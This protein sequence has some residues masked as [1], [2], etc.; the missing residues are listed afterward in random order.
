MVNY[1]AGEFT[2]WPTAQNITAAQNLVS[3]D[4]SGAELDGSCS[5]DKTT[6]VTAG[7]SDSTGS[8][9][10]TSTASGAATSSGGSP[11]PNVPA[12]AG[13]VVGG[14]LG[15]GS[16]SALI[17][18]FTLRRRKARKGAGVAELHHEYKPAGGHEPGS[19]E[20]YASNTIIDTNPVGDEA[21][22]FHEL[23]PESKSYHELPSRGGGFE[24]GQLRGERG[25]ETPRFELADNMARHEM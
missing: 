21:A 14:V 16:I 13:G 12:I 10:V 1:D 23:A 22:T 6:T 4:A 19:R 20:G 15:I 9:S 24:E 3:V 7:G 5:S 17:I 8:S 11:S 2:V 25:P 18:Y